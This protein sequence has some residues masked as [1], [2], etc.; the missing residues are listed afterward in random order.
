AECVRYRLPARHFVAYL[1]F[2]QLIAPLGAA[3]RVVLYVKLRVQLDSNSFVDIVQIGGGWG[4][5]VPAACR[6][7]KRFE[8]LVVGIGAKANSVDKGTNTFGN[9]GS[10][11]SG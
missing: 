10:Y 5:E 3:Q 8:H 9:L 4:L 7:T 1:H 2:Y 11:G 6:L